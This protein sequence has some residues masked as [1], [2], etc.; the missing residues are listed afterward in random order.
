MWECAVFMAG[1]VIGDDGCRRE[2]THLFPFSI[3]ASIYLC[4]HSFYFYSKNFIINLLTKLIQ[5]YR[6]IRNPLLQFYFISHT[7]FYIKKF[8]KLSIL[9]ND[10]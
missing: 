5:V 3:F 7:S 1:G 9:Y 6:F 10:R 4:I 2:E 8:S